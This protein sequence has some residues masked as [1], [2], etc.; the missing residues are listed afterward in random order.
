[1]KEYFKYGNGYVNIDDENLYLTNSGNWSETHELEEKSPKSVRK[2]NHKTFR[3]NSYYF[4]IG[5]VLLLVVIGIMNKNS[6]IAI[7]LGIIIIVITAFKYMRSESGKKYKIPLSKIKNFE[8]VDNSIKINFVNLNNEIDFETINK[9]EEK[10][11]I[12]LEKL[13]LNK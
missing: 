11:L 7:P 2:N 3:I 13:H 12:Y 10:G 4:I 8:I 6:H 1:M 9:V 5:L